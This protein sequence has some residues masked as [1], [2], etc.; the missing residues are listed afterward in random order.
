M[1]LHIENWIDESRHSENVSTLYKDAIIC[2]KSGAYRASLLFSYLG[3]MTI[4]KERIISSNKPNLFPQ[5]EWDLIIKKLQNEDTWEAA[6]FDATQQQGKI[7]QTS[8]ARTKDPIFN[9]NDNVRIQIKYWK[10]RRNDCAHFKD[11][12]I[13]TYHVESFWAFIESNLPKITIEGGLQSLLNKIDKHFDPTFTPPNKDITQ[14]VK[15]VEFSV[16]STKLKEFWGLLLNDSQWNY[17][18]FINKQKFANR[19]FEVN[20]DIINQNLVEVLKGNE[21]YLK[22]FLSNHP[23]KF[24]RFNYSAEEIRKFWKTTLV[25]CDN[26]LGIYTTL[27]RNCLIPKAEISEANELVLNK[28]KEYH[29]GPIEHQILIANGFFESFKTCIINNSNFEEYLWVNDRADLISDM[30]VSNSA[31]IDI[32][33]RLCLVY[34]HSTNSN[35]LIERFDRELM[36]KEQLRE[37]YKQI[38]QQNNITIPAKLKKYFA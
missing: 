38:I 4:L 15:E 20:L 24:L 5:R 19:S 34:N 13:D 28:I 6:V 27:L 31:D 30:I 37:E 2:Y 36:S 32:V 25:R 18:L 8:T 21:H 7:D 11:N 12:I 17:D 22:D 23:D 16:E 3:F 35:W 33:N 14:L 1:K 29:V 10:D 9:L 26:I